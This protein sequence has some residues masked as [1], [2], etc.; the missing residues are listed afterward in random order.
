MG[1]E[2]PLS[3]HR[4]VIRPEWIDHNDDMNVACYV[5]VFDLERLT[6]LRPELII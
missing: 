3:L 4:G 5:L 1:E 2:A 6:E